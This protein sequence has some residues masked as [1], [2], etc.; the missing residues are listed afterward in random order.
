MY[1]IRL[2]ENSFN[3]CIGQP[4]GRLI[5]GTQSA[6]ALSRFPLRMAQAT[7]AVVSGQVL[8]A[9]G[10]KG[11]T[12]QSA[13]PNFDPCSCVSNRVQKSVG[14]CNSLIEILQSEH[15][16]VRIPLQRRGPLRPVQARN[17]RTGVRAEAS[18]DAETKTASRAA[19]LPATAKDSVEEGLKLFK[20]GRVRQTSL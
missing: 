7:H 13:K 1:Y 6:P 17:G 14:K 12:K 8:L 11:Q 10:N 15:S 20:K 3:F 16:F 5:L 19:G 9:P 4:A 18:G 2:C